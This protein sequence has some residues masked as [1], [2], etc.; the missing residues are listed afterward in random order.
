MRLINVRSRLMVEFFGDIPPYAILSHRWREGEVSFQD[1]HNQ[2]Q[3]RPEKGNGKIDALCL[4]ARSDGHEWVWIDTCCIDKS[5][6]A[7][8]SE[9]INSMFEWYQRSEICYAYLDDVTS[10]DEGLLDS[11][12]FKRG[13]TLQELVAPRN[14]KFYCDGNEGWNCLGSRQS[15][16]FKLSERTRVPYQLLDGHS[17][18]SDYTVASRMSW[19]A[20][21]K[22]TRIEDMAYCLMGIFNINMPLLYG[23]GA[24]AFVRLQEQIIANSNDHTIFAWKDPALYERKA[25]ESGILAYS[26]KLFASS[27][28]TDLRQRDNIMISNPIEVTAAG[29]R[30]RTIACLTK[31]QMDEFRPT[32]PGSYLFL[33]LNCELERGQRNTCIAIML[34]WLGG[35]RYSRYYSDRLFEVDDDAICTDSTI[36]VEKGPYVDRPL[37]AI[38]GVF[39]RC[40][41]HIQLPDEGITLLRLSEVQ[42]RY[43]H[44]RSRLD[45]QFSREELGRGEG[46]MR[47]LVFDLGDGVIAL[48]CIHLPSSLTAEQR[49]MV[50]TLKIDQRKGAQS[51][52]LR[53]QQ[54]FTQLY[55]FSSGEGYTVREIEVE[56]VNKCSTEVLSV[57]MSYQ[58]QDYVLKLS[59]KASKSWE[60]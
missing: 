48:V 58:G 43:D 44:S 32:M 12:W 33:P 47:G 3:P 21:R 36:F 35:K 28:S 42:G 38:V 19:A 54:L 22:T 5:S 29:L 57:S 46:I 15:L 27:T 2:N 30:T 13:W 20:D 24:N 51:I 37:S 56:R 53:L 49:L 55:D 23:E 4:Q 45:I 11:E 26:P 59:F 40:T 8:L 18:P 9:A 10:L 34:R 14:L 39:Y 60:I 50:Q 17:H 6:S 41:L 16:R 52:H 7:E 31:A 25:F 1:Y